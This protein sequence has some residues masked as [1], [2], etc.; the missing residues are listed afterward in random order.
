[1]ED[2]AHILVVDDDEETVTLLREILS[3]E[4]YSV[5]T[6][7]DGKTALDRINSR[8]PDLVIS[9]IHMPD[10]DGM[11][12]L[13]AFLAGHAMAPSPRPQRAFAIIFALVSA[14]TVY[15][16]ADIEYP[17]HGLV[18]IESIDAILRSL[19]EEIGVPKLLD[20]RDFSGEGRVT[21]VPVTPDG[22]T[23]TVA[24]RRLRGA[25]RIARLTAGTWYAGELRERP[26]GKKPAADL[27]GNGSNA[28]S[29]PLVVVR[30]SDG[31][32]VLIDTSLDDSFE[33]E[34]P[35]QARC[36]ATEV[37]Q[38]LRILRLRDA[39]PQPGDA[40]ASLALEILCCTMR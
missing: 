2:P 23:V 9:D 5:E 25:G 27:N 18:R 39:T 22:G 24:G 16:I 35:L 30:A 28:D 36:R 12:L 1:M 11:G 19:L 26:L 6:A 15:F 21:L 33:D 13:S 31:L 34:T 32:V 17:R 40:T 10:L 7:G 4:G 8:G 29:F 20:V 38:G 14:V 37:A 3:K